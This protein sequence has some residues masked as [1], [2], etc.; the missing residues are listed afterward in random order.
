[1]FVL[2]QQGMAQ[3]WAFIG[4]AAARDCSP[5]GQ[6]RPLGL[7][8]KTW[9]RRPLGAVGNDE[10]ISIDTRGVSSTENRP[11]GHGPRGA[12]GIVR[13]S[14]EDARLT[15][16][17]GRPRPLGEALAPAFAATPRCVCLE[18]SGSGVGVGVLL[19]S[20]FCLLSSSNILPPYAE[21]DLAGSF[22]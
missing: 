17:R 1:S 10:H 11:T 16:W 4:S 8:I 9:R 7:L 19:S 2:P 3:C 22:V 5:P 13:D 21:F 6:E 12:P 15:L 20:V 14:G 18:N